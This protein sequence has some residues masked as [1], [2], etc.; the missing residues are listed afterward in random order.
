MKKEE[1]KEKDVDE[2]NVNSRAVDSGDG[3]NEGADDGSDSN[4]D[5]DLDL[6]S[7]SD[8]EGRPNRGTGTAGPKRPI[9]SGNKGQYSL[10][11]PDGEDA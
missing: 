2:T 1:I 3:S 4:Q 8:S 7:D 10:T 9:G 5:P 11:D 6:D